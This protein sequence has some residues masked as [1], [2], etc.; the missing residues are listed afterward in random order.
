MDRYTV[1]IIVVHCLSLSGNGIDCKYLKR[2][3][4]KLVSL[5][6]ATPAHMTGKKN[7]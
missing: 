7:T 6:L 2:L 4:G 3:F 5:A 1:V